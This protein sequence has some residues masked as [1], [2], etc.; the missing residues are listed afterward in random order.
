MARL[1]L[2]RHGETEWAVQGRHTGRTD[3]PLTDHGREA[4]A[5]AGRLLA[6]LAPSPAHV[7]TSPRLRARDTAKLAGL[8]VEGVDDRLAEWDYGDYEGLT[9]AFI[10]ET[11][12]DWHVW[13]HGSPGGE[14]PSQVSARAD[15]VLGFVRPLMAD[16][17]VVLVG[18][19]HFSRVLAARWIGLPASH[20][21]HIALE[22]AGITVL[23]SDR[24]TPW[25]EKVNVRV[26]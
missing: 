21:R 16:G 6:T 8:P 25:L 26:P 17:D 3:V 12:P 20:G 24:G 7:L 1:L 15:T 9:T 19:G 13:T 23:S 4:A 11:I 14:S 22:P 2:L 5:A 18:H 10:R